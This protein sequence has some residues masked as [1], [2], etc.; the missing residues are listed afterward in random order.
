M[1]K[2]TLLLMV[3]CMSV[4]AFA[5][6]GNI[7]YVL[8]GGVTNDYGWTSKADML[9]GFNQD[10]NTANNV[11]VTATWYTWETLDVILAAS[12][13]VVRIPTFAA[14][15][16]YVV[17]TS[18]KWQWLHD[19]IVATGQ[20]QGIAAIAES[21]NAYWR[22]ETSAFFVC[23]KRTVWPISADYAVAG[24]PS[25]FI[26]AWKHAFAGPAAYDGSAE[27][28]IPDPYKEGA[29]FDGWYETA[30]FSG[31]KVTSIPAGA[32]GDKTLY[33][34]WVEY[35]PACAEVWALTAGTST[36][37]G[38]VVT[39]VNGTTAYIQDATAGLLVEFA[40]A[41]AVAKGD[42]ITVSGT[43][44]ALGAYVKITG[45]A[46]SAKEAATAPAAQT[47]TLADLVVGVA[48]YMFEYVYIEGLSITAY[49]GSDPTVSDGINSITLAAGLNPD[50]FPVNSKINVRVVVSYTDALILTGVT[51]DVTFAPVPRPEGVA[52]PAH[53]D[54]KY[55]LTNRWLVSNVMDNF[56]AN[57]IG[58]VERVR[59]MIAKNGKMYF[60]D[61]QLE[62]LTI[63]D[64][65]T[66]EKLAPI[67]LNAQIFATC[68]RPVGGLYP[69]NDLQQDNAGH[70]LVGNGI[71]S[72]AGRFQVWKID[73]ATGNG[74]VVIDEVLAENP[75]FADKGLLRFDAFG[76]YGD[77]DGNA[78]IMAADAN[79]MEVFKW[80]VTNGVAD[81][82][83]VISIDTDTEGTFLTGFSN[84]GT[85]PRIFP[86]DENY[87]YLDGNATLPTLIDM[88][89]NI[90]DGFFNVPVE[91]ENWA[92]GAV[93]GGSTAGNNGLA[94]FELGGEYFFIMSSTN[95]NATPP[96]AFRLFKFKDGN[97][98][99]EDIESLWT[100]PEAGMGGASLTYRSSVPSVEVNETAKTAT[101]YLYVGENGYGAYEF[102]IDD[103]SGIKNPVT[104]KLG[105]SVSGTTIQLSESVAS[106]QVYNIAG[107]LVT[108]KSNTA[109]AQVS[110]PGIYVVKAI[111][112]TGET[113]VL[114]VIVK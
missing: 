15:G 48:S 61:S 21:D 4:M 93:S 102:K 94:E 2:I 34:K 95:T 14:S 26:P 57:R 25:A 69:L 19:Y 35:V 73:L 87:F 96:S 79:S 90:V 59:G 70:V 32:E 1:K 106:V 91:V 72:N 12:D 112:L 5:A 92:T 33:A 82:A 29:T 52:Y 17:L 104:G 18:S 68:S 49:N 100:L 37:A 39:Y 99:F 50:D 43:I 113:V 27:I 8:N 63:V 16:F 77:V 105:L 51:S 84:P 101:I 98:E 23:R 62:Q 11:P 83:E 108:K 9:V 30:D 89:G 66:G 36:K 86:M 111:S 54:G 42:K 81:P 3:C 55:T 10:Y 80:T 103:G 109:S 7:T 78:I 46:L 56:S 22:Y 38:G 45:A 58:E 75:D 28:V 6:G 74:T 40:S 24:Q 97:K 76:V 88:D 53:G 64:G 41:P 67:K 47:V 13:P 20:A 71:T 85:A 114:K 31:A 44:A 107:Q 110:A 60:I 65:A